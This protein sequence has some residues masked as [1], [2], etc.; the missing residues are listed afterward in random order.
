MEREVRSIF[1]SQNPECRAII[2]RSCPQVPSLQFFHPS[3]NGMAG[4]L[5]PMERKSPLK[6]QSELEDVPEEILRKTEEESLTQAP[7]E[8]HSIVAF[9][10]C[11]SPLNSPKISPQRSIRRSPR[12]VLFS[13]TTRVSP[14]AGS[15][16]ISP[17]TPTTPS[18]L[19]IS[20]NS[21]Q[22]SLIKPGGFDGVDSSQLHTPS[23]IGKARAPGALGKFGN[24]FL[25]SR[26]D[27]KLIGNSNI[28]MQ[29]CDCFLY[30]FNGTLKPSTSF[31]FSDALAPAITKHVTKQKKTLRDKTIENIEFRPSNLEKYIANE[32]GLI[33]PV[34]VQY[35]VYLFQRILLCCKEIN[36]NK[37]KNKMLGT[38]KP[39]TD[40]K[41]KLR[42]Q[43][44]GRIFMQN[45][46]DVVSFKNGN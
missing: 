2:R 44:K 43:L 6:F 18:T 34:R 15:S 19:S 38:N 35:K 10:D 23:R 20:E 7:L 28:P 36:P 12:R 33:V 41:G 42:L 21:S 45:V 32:M 26:G 37:P 9:A 22:I 4:Y 46:T 31:L 1:D 40:K 16:K 25:K 8:Q 39:L 14:K 29:I 5:A 3:K 17:R 30:Q 24:S 13:K 27:R 11:T